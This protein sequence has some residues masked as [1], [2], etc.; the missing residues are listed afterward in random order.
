MYIWTTGHM[1]SGEWKNDKPDGMGT[2]IW[3]DGQRYTGEWFNGKQHGQGTHVFSNGNIIQVFGSMANLNLQTILL[4]TI[5][6]I[7]IN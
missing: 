1:Y 2:Y 3:S 6:I 5:V 7:I 4:V